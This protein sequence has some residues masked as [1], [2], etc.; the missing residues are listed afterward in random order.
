MR[1]QIGNGI[2]DSMKFKSELRPV[3][4]FEVVLRI[5]FGIDLIMILTLAR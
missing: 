1:I 2:H 5:E 3:E 4:A